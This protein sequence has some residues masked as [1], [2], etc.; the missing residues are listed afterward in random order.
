M[1]KKWNGI[2]DSLRRA[3]QKR[4]TKSGQA[5]TSSNKYKYEAILDFLIP[6]LAE[7]KGLS[8]VPDEKDDDDAPET[9]DELQQQNSI[10]D[11]HQPPDE[12]EETTKSSPLPPATTP[13]KRVSAEKRPSYAGRKRKLLNTEVKPQDSASSQLMAYI[14]AEKEA[15]SRNSRSQH[16]E[17]H[18]VDAFLAGIAPSLKSLDPPLLLAAKGK[19]FNVVQEYELQQLCANGQQ[20]MAYE[21]MCLSTSS[22]QTSSAAT[23]V[24]NTLS[25]DG[26]CADVYEPPHF[27]KNVTPTSPTIITEEANLSFYQFQ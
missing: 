26:S 24:Q 27:S 16:S 10:E 2:R 7:R 20:S 25:E 13:A 14:L 1:Q 17:Q 23:S 4:K 21:R 5:A 3:R 22:P 15:D 18:P 8:N 9:G 19:I 11:P 6:H 12:P